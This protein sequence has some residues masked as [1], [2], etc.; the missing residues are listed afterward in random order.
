MRLLEHQSKEL[1]ASFGLNFTQSIV[2]DSAVAA[3]EA[4]V[5][6]GSPAVL[7][8]QVPFGG[9]GKA[10]AVL[11]VENDREAEAAARQ[12]L[13]RE[14]RGVRVEKISIEPKLSFARE[15][16]L[17]ATWDT[18]TKLPVALLSAAGGVD[19]ESSQGN[20]ARRTFDPSLGLR[21]YEGREMAAEIG[22]AGRVLIGVGSHLEKLA[23]AFLT[24]DAVTAEI[25]PLVEEGSTLTGLDAHLE[26]D[27][28]AAYR[29]QAR[30]A[31][32]GE[33]TSTAAGRP[34]TPL[35]IEAARIDALDHRG[36]AGRVVE[37][38]GDLGLLIGGGGASLT[39][40]DAIQRHGGNPANYCE[41]GGN[42]TEA[43][44]AA[45]T[46]LLLSKPGVKKLAVI[47]NVVNNTR[48]DVMARGVLDGLRAAG[49][50]PATT[51]SV[52]RIPGSW[53]QEA[54]GLLAAAGVEA[55]GRETSLDACARLAVAR[56]STH[57]A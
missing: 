55:L 37:F 47:M 19:V 35:E 57:A 14:V 8:A 56:T 31:P 1:L 34:P 49:L 54:R 3:R 16:Y 21:A 4:V 9:R 7:K 15:L 42:P 11:F 48:A 45:L 41:V 46:H 44:V 5:Q 22:L 28:D 2:V 17:G 40:F 32:L 51:I 52:F 26:I 12:L 27:D 23:Q 38:D 30:L 18:A 43:K 10:G 13:G 6:L 24:L 25:N 20:I 39:V 50:E 33:I 36:V 53:E 29:Q